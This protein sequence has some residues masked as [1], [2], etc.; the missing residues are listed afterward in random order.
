MAKTSRKAA[1]AKNSK[2]N[3]HTP[4]TK[5]PGESSEKPGLN[6][7]D[8]SF[9]SDLFAEHTDE[10]LTDDLDENYEGDS[11]P[12]GDDEQIEDPVRIYLMQMGEIPL[13]SRQEEIHAAKRID[14]GR[15]ALPSR[16]S[17]E[18]LRS[19]SGDCHAGKHPGWQASA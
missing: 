3:G 13:L 14:I 10:E 16:D 11:E 9:D 12:T 8:D 19:A 18:R 17:G 5:G 7:V 15:R 6:A 2:T 1:V 4:R